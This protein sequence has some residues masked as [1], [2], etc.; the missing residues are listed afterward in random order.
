MKTAWF[1]AVH[2]LKNLYPLTWLVCIAK[3]SRSGYY[4]WF[5]NKRTR[6]ERK[7]NEQLL[8]EHIMAIHHSHPFYG[9]PRMTVALK[10]EGF[11]INHK[12]VY[13]LMKEMNIQSIIRKKRRYFGRQASVVHPNRLNRKFKTNQYNQLYVTDIRP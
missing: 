6:M 1:E 13:R 7:Q 10:K 2:E 9:Y 11:H 3:V 12:R 4:K 8:K 5:K